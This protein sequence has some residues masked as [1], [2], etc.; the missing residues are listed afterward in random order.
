[1][2]TCVASAGRVRETVLADQDDDF[3]VLVTISD[4][5]EPKKELIRRVKLL[6]SPAVAA[7]FE[8]WTRTW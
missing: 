2:D 6:N 8:A 1:M 4:G 5:D 7:E 3:L